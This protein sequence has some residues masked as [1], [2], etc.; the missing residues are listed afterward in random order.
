MGMGIDSLQGVRFDAS[1]TL[2]TKN[3]SESQLRLAAKLYYIENL[4]QAEVARYVKVSQAQVSR[5]LATARERGIVQIT[6]ADYDVRNSYLEEELIR[7]YKLTAAAVV[8]VIGKSTAEDLRHS[9][10]RFA[11]PFACGMLRKQ[12]IVAVGGGRSIR[13]L[14][15]QFPDPEGRMRFVL[16]AMGNVGSNVVPMDAS[17]VGRLLAER[18]GCPFLSLNSPAF[19]RDPKARK[20]VLQMEQIRDMH[21]RFDDA[22]VALL[23]VGTPDESIFALRGVFT[24][25]ELRSIKRSGAVGEICGRFY[26][27]DGNECDTV[28]KHR[29]IGIELEQLR[30]VPLVIGVTAG[31]SRTEALRG[32]IRGGLLK[33]LAIDEIGADALL[34]NSVNGALPASSASRRKARA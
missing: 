2:M 22:G 23:S 13:A 18:C 28:W 17:E 29:V 10:G 21:Q 6:V 12:S 1:I 14:I 5:L 3:Y 20:T 7:R 30:N 11:A 24:D 15:E 32:A 26:D 8:K 9:V 34:R 31:E 33:A 19:V 27:A 4:S 25:A 16:Q